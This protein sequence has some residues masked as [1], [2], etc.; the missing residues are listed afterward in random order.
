MHFGYYHS[1]SS[2]SWKA[3]RFSKHC[4]RKCTATD[5]RFVIIIFDL[6]ANT[7]TIIWNVGGTRNSQGFSDDWWWFLSY[8]EASEQILWSYSWLD[9]VRQI[10]GYWSGHSCNFSFFLFAI[11]KWSASISFHWISNSLPFHLI[12]QSIMLKGWYKI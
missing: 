8:F 9:V 1:F 6:R 2:S 4:Y 12:N 5:I 7:W 11:R 3:L 10:D